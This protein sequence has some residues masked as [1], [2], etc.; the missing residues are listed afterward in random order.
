MWTCFWKLRVQ[1]LDMEA[2]MLEKIIETLDPNAQKHDQ[3]RTQTD[4]RPKMTYNSK[5][6]CFPMGP[7]SIRTGSFQSFWVIR[8]FKNRI[9]I[10]SK[11]TLRQDITKYLFSQ[12]K[13]KPISHYP[14]WSLLVT[15]ALPIPHA[16]LCFAVSATML[17]ACGSYRKGFQTEVHC[18]SYSHDTRS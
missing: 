5:T 11:T 13:V 15:L 9:N 16:V 7:R 6:K 14:L 17:R 18:G 4:I 1:R 2:D 10:V 8:D 12:W 3:S